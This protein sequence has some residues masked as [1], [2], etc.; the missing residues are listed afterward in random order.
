MEYVGNVPNRG[1]FNIRMPRRANGATMVAWGGALRSAI[2]LGTGTTLG[3]PPPF[4]GASGV[5]VGNPSADGV[6]SC[7]KVTNL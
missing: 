4:D 7:A 5:Y 3:C 6:R 1:R 2:D